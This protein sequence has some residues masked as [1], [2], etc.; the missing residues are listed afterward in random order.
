M[1]NTVKQGIISKISSELKK[2][3]ILKKKPEPQ[4]KQKIRRSREKN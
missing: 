4:I 1:E 3:Q 2:K